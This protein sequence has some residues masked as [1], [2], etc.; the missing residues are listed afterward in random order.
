MSGTEE[1]SSKASFKPNLRETWRVILV[2]E[3]DMLL[4]ESLRRKKSAKIKLVKRFGERYNKK[5]LIGIGNRKAI[6]L[7]DSIAFFNLASPFHPCSPYRWH[8]ADCD[9]G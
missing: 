7:K 5:A 2:R 6:E 1:A 3:A 4:S 9:C 8:D